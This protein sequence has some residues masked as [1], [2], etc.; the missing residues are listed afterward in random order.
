MVPPK[1]AFFVAALALALAAVALIVWQPT[2]SE[3]GWTMQ[4]VQAPLSVNTTDRPC[5]SV[6]SSLYFD[7]FCMAIIATPGGVLL[8]GTFD[9]GPWTSLMGFQLS[10]NALCHIGC[11][12]NATWTSPDG[13]GRILW[14][15]S[16][17]LVAI[18][19]LN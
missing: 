1:R 13:T 12:T 9:H 18:E 14:Q 15:F 11:P 8:N 7:R 3:S 5:S 4:T 16:T 6:D 2:S 10:N 19:A 17:L